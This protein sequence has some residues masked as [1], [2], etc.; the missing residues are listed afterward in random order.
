MKKQA[1]IILLGFLLTIAAG[2]VVAGPSM[3][4]PSPRTEIRPAS[5]GSGHV[6][7]SGHWKWSGGRYVWSTGHWVKARPGR[8]WVAGHWVKRGNHWVWIKGRWR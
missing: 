1:W 8:Q 5:P 6:W 3:A 2:C 4:P 7:I